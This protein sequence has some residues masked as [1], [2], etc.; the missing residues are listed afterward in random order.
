MQ[1]SSVFVKLHA[2]SYTTVVLKAGFKQEK[3]LKTE[4]FHRK[5]KKKKGIKPK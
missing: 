1:F 2:A 3:L 5:L 4:D